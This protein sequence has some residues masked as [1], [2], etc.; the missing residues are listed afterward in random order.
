MFTPS[1]TASLLFLRGLFVI[2]FIV[3]LTF[4]CVYAESWRWGAFLSLLQESQQGR[5]EK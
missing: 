4:G 3:G 5:T 2:N 1:L